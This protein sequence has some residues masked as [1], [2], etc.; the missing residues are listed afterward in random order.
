MLPIFPRNDNTYLVEGMANGLTGDPINNATVT[1]E[2]RTAKYPAGSVVVSGT[3]T[4]VTGSD[5]NYEITVD[6]ATDISAGTQYSLRVLA[7]STV[8][9]AEVED[10]VMGRGRTGR[11]LAT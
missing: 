7:T 11:S 2:L 5:G 3:G 1:W 6:D 9:K 4:Y 10:Y 8:G